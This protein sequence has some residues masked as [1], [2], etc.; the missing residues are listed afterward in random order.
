MK[1]TSKGRLAV[2]SLVDLAINSNEGEPVSLSEISK[3]QHITVTFLEQIFSALKKKGIVKS[4][5]G[6]HGGYL[7]A[8]NPNLIMLLDV[9]EATDENL[10]INKC[11]GVDFGCN[12]NGKKI[13][14]L[15]HNLWSELT[16][17]I[18][19]FLNS[20]SI[21][22]VKKNEYSSFFKFQNNL[23]MN[24]TSFVERSSYD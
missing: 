3:R 2:T 17:H 11:N 23:T 15:T 7:F 24:E 19:F 21:E 8:K 9:I 10:K 18:L 14:C 5:R 13:K 6:P 20:I 12:R 4:I 1:L 16:N 22:D